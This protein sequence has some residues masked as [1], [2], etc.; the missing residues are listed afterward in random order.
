M[1]TPHHLG[2]RACGHGGHHP[3]GHHPY[4]RNDHRHRLALAVPALCQAPQ[5]AQVRQ[6]FLRHGLRPARAG[7]R[8][9]HSP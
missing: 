4:G 1:D 6:S 9:D 2:T 5:P 8:H 3:Y 7:W